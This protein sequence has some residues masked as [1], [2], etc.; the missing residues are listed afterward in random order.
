MSDRT[1]K[2]QELFDLTGRTAIVTGG[3]THLGTAFTEALCDL[4]AKV[5]IASRRAGLC[6]E[7]AEGLRG[8]GMD[9]T[10]TGCDVTDESQVDALVQRVIDENDRLDIAVCNAGGSFTTSYPP[11]ADIDE[12]RRTLEINL[13]GTYITAQSA[14][15]AMIPAKRGSII[16]LGSI[17]ATLS[18]DPRIYNAEF[19]RS[20]PPYLAAKGGVLNLTRAF[21]AEFGQYGITANCISPGQ[22]P[23]GAV[24]PDQ[25]ETFRNMIPLQ[26]TGLSEDLKGTVALLASDAGTWITGQ[27]FRVDGGWSIW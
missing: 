6:Q 17:G 24:N 25:T 9:V 13:T 10:G 15:R 14:G 3:G 11:D 8:R 20:G 21:A 12:F 2:V 4:G 22:I 27:E 18:M 1:R 16:T 26:R 5:Y 7:V 19:R 23:K